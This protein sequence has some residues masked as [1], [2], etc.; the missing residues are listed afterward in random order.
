MAGGARIHCMGPSL[1][2]DQISR[3]L[4]VRHTLQACFDDIERMNNQSRNDSRAET[5]ERL[6]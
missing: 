3:C 2:S 6:Y 5:G 4:R 1:A